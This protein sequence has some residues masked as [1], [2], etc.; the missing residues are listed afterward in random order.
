M[1]ELARAGREVVVVERENRIGVGIS[2]RNSEV[3]HAGVYYPAGLRK[4]RLCVD[5]RA[6]LY[7]FCRDYGVRHRRCGNLLVA[8]SEN[9]AGKLAA[10]KAQAQANG[11]DNL[12]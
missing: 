3:I 9:E 4:A 6:R 12:V 7:D 10:L 1:R 11:V 2:S 5:G 8:T